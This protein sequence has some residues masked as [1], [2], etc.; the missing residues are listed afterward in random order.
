MPQH[1]IGL[2]DR[3]EIDDEARGLGSLL[4]RK[5]AILSLMTG[6]ILIARR[7]NAIGGAG[8]PRDLTPIFHRAQPRFGQTRNRN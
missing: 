4:A 6:V 2:D 8:R 3:V 7:L 1:L 5:R